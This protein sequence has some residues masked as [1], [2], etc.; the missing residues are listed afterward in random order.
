[1]NFFFAIGLPQQNQEALAFW[2]G[3]G[4]KEFQNLIGDIFKLR[5]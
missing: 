1:M 2:N 3:E 4:I 5:E